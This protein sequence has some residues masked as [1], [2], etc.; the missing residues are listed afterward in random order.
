MIGTRIRPRRPLDLRLTLA[1][2]RPLYFAGS[3]EAWRATWT[4]L[5][6]A[7]TRI[8]QEIAGEVTV[9]AWG[10]GAEWA[11]AHAPALLGE[12][13]R[14][15]DF[16]PRHPLIRDLQRRFRGLRLGRT[17]AVFE[18]LLRAITEQKVTG[19]EAGRAY[20]GML[21]AF[22]E[23][24]PG[25]AGPRLPPS[26]Q[27]IAATPYFAFHRFGLERRRA[28]TLIACARAA[29]RLEAGVDV[30]FI[31]GVGAW[32]QAEVLAVARGDPDAVSVG[33]YHIPSMVGWALAGERRADDARM[34]ELLEPYR[35]Q[36]GRVI[37]LLELAGVGAPR[38]GPRMPLRPFAWSRV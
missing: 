38:R 9:E 13:D 22:G 16:A 34:L 12:D 7:T 36:R 29:P 4:P 21:R 18:A 11:V 17:D 5:G 8:V 14:P 31:R 20:H 28:E 2:V 23:A 10:A 27:R 25:P 26:A 1:L 6:P 3:R 19:A 33:D 32:T 37:R 30:G 15:E 24:P 35:G